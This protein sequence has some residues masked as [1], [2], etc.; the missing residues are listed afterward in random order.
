MLIVVLGFVFKNWKAVLIAIAL[1]AGAAWYAD[2]MHKEY[3]A[4]I[5]AEIQTMEK[6]N[7]AAKSAADA[8]QAQVDACYARG[9][10]FTWDRATG[11][12]HGPAASKS[13]VRRHQ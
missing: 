8:A 6:A 2:K 7:A 5:Q 9:A 10:G 11:V 3:E 1:G 13:S 4:G 12:C